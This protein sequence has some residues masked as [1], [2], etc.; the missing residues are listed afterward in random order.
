MRPYL[1]ILKD[2]FREAFA[3][4]VLWIMLG[5]IA[6]FLLAIAPLGFDQGLSTVLQRE[7][8]SDAFGLMKRLR[9]DAA[10]DKPSP[11][12]HLWNQFSDD[13]RE[14]AEK[15]IDSEDPSGRDRS[16]S[17]RRFRG[18]L[19]KV[20]ASADFYDK[21]SWSGEP[22]DGELRDKLSASGRKGI[23]EVNVVNRH[24]IESAFSDFVDLGEDNAVY[25][26]YAGFRVIDTPLPLSAEQQT[27]T[28]KGII[29]VALTFL[30]GVVG[31]FISILVTASFIPRTFEPGEITLLLSKPVSR[32]FLF[33]TKFLGGCAFTLL[34]AAFLLV[35]FWLIAG[36]RFGVW[37]HN[38]LW[39]IPVYVFVF[40]IYYAVSAGTG[41]VWRN[42]IVSIVMTILFWLVI[43]GVGITKGIVEELALNST[44]ITEIVPVGDGLLTATSGLET[45][46][47]DS[48]TKKWKSVFTISSGGPPAFARRF[49]FANNRFRPVYDSANERIVAMQAA[50]GRGG[51]TQVVTG[52]RADEWARQKAG[53]TPGQVNS[54]FVDS[55]DRVLLVGSTGIFQLVDKEKDKP[56]SSQTNKGAEKMRDWLKKTT[57]GLVAFGGGTDAFPNLRPKKLPAWKSPVSYA[58]D[59]STDSLAVYSTGTIQVLQ[60]NE[61]G[62]FELTVERKLE[63]EDLAIVGI[64]GQRVLLVNEDGS[65][66]ILDANTLQEIGRQT[67][68]DG[69]APKLI[70]SSPNG[71]YLA[72]LSHDKTVWIY[73]VANEKPLVWTVPGQ[74]DISSIAFDQDN[75]LMVAD[76]IT[77]VRSYDLAQGSVV[78][79]F[80]PPT[81]TTH[82]L[83]SY[84]IQP[85]YTILPKP[86]ELGNLITWLTTDQ[87]SVALGED[88]DNASL[89]TERIK[90]DVWTPIWSN[91]AFLIV[92]LGVTCFYVSRRDF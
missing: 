71:L 14:Q 89:Q 79:T 49:A 46:A 73:D 55:K 8:V 78:Q 10:N 63:N 65:A 22:M 91:V 5:L 75:R 64:T 20:I 81:T 23:D 2:S 31:I 41:A 16:R 26:S 52:R 53:N 29:N 6:I 51:A 15:V 50:P 87:D 90:I 7:E 18:E 4:R 70:E 43:T 25:L 36:V 56:D 80:S 47:W 88:P 39:C 86:G 62:Q 11:G 69:P 9:E 82:K 61:N 17:I 67:A 54:I 28:V 30:L 60:P 92:I 58:F 34:N 57:G 3:S 27:D 13:F 37:N 72:V 38:L 66:T 45:Q 40:A 19:N 32:S 84:L 33:L 68:F 24:A 21:E 74:G 12:R 83:Y 44:R 42:A 77:R 48:D 1:A 85:I 35:G 76:R 59:R